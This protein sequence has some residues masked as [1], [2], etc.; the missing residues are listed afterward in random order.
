MKNEQIVVPVSVVIPCFCCARTIKRAIDSVV[1]QT[2]RPAEIILIDDASG[3]E[4]LSVLH[5]IEN[6]HSGWIKVI[7]LEEN[8]GAASARNAG[9][10]IA[11]QPYIAFLDADDSWHAKKIEIQYAYMAAHT[12]VVLCGHDRHIL[13]QTDVLP[14]WRVESSFAVERISVWSLLFSNRFVTPSVMLRRDVS[15]RFNENQHYMEDHLLWSEIAC[16]GGGV[17]KLVVALAAIYKQPFGEAGLSSQIW[18]MGISDFTNYQRLYQKGCIH[19]WQWWMLSL[20]SLLKFMR[21]LFIYWGYMR[22]TK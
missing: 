2:Q 5:A 1:Q 10:A 13:K 21:R 16:G 9:W 18:L 12:E 19:W 20:Y 17:V 11:T 8:L 14:N 22:W 3:D 7:A 4:T 15:Q 6:Q